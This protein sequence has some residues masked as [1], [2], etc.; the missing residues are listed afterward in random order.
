MEIDKVIKQAKF[1]NS[2][3]KAIVNLLYTYNHIRDIHQPMF[4]KHNIQSQ[5]YN[6]LRILK[7]KFPE[8]V[9]PGYIKEVM[10]DK[11]A[12]LTRLIDKLQQKG[13]V[14][15]QVCPKNKRQMDITITSSGIE[16]LQAISAEMTDLD[17]QNRHMKDEDYETLS[18]LLDKMRG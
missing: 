8:P 1:T 4:K 6:V 18:Y 10:L 15:R 16:K 11:G 2:Y 14:E 17:N 7:G 13:W 12:D 3:Q 9:R 5:H